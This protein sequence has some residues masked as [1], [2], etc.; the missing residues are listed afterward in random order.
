MAVIT[1]MKHFRR[2]KAGRNKVIVSVIVLNIFDIRVLELQYS[3]KVRE[4]TPFVVDSAKY[5]HFDSAVVLLVVDSFAWFHQCRRPIVQQ[6][7]RSKWYLI[8][9]L[10]LLARPWMPSAQSITSRFHHYGSNNNCLESIP[11]TWSLVKKSIRNGTATHSQSWN[12]RIMISIFTYLIS[13]TYVSE[14]FSLKVISC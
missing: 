8:S 7:F 9:G 11:I 1:R 6:R 3:I 10:V 12:R 4:L 14:L 13:T 5:S 2:T